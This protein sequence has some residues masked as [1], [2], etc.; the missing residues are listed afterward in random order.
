MEEMKVRE[1]MRPLD[2]FPSISSTA[3]FMEAVEALEKAD[4]E[5]KS[6][7][8]PQRIL[9]VYDTTGK[10]V[11]KMSPMDVV[12]GLEPDYFHIDIPKSTSYYQLIQTVHESTKTELRLWKNPLKELC[13][14]AYNLKIQQFI[15]MPTPDHMVRIDNKMEEVLHLFVVERHDSLFIQDG[16]GIVGLILF[17]DMYKKISETMKSCPLPT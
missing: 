15:K 16:L 1:L 11:G 14:K 12:Q 10:V 4:L 8:A 7:K 17:S 5:F 13:N 9:L 2:E 6:G 3:T